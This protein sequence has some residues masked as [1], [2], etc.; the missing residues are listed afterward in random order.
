MNSI[1]IYALVNTDKHDDIEDIMQIACCNENKIDMFMTAD[2]KLVEIYG[3]LFN[4]KTKI[5][6]L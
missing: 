2:P 1:F 3:H 5:K 4:I 6:L